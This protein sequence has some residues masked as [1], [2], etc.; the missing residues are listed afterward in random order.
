MKKTKQP[1]VREDRASITLTVSRT[2]KVNAIVTGCFFIAATV[3][4]IIGLKLYDPLLKGNDFLHQGAAH[5]GQIVLGAVFELV[6]IVANC[7]TAIMLFPYLKVYNER[8]ALG[9]YTFR[10]LECVFI[11]LGVVSVLSLLTLSHTYHT[12]NTPDTSYFNAIGSIAKA[13]HDWTFLLGP[14]FMLGINTFIYSQ[15]MTM[16][17]I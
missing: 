5:S 17:F 14:K 8:L 3:F 1:S 2:D 10:V 9:Y 16:R 4:A 13:F 6:L 15:M 11:L 7:G 12:A